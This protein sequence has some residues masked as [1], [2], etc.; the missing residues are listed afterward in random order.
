MDKIKNFKVFTNA[1]KLFEGSKIA[2]D[3]N[4]I[5]TVYEDTLEGKSTRLWS[6]HNEWSV[7]EDFDTVIRIIKE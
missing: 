4:E 1:G 3:V 6:P 7:Q 5:I 2:I